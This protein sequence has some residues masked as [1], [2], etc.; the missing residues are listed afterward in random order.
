MLNVMKQ[1]ASIF[2]IIILSILGCSDCRNVDCPANQNFEFEVKNSSGNS[3]FKA[4]RFIQIIETD[5]ITVFGIDQSNNETE[6]PIY[7]DGIVLFFRPLKNINNYLVKYS[8]AKND[9]LAFDFTIYNDDCCN[10]VIT[11]YLVEVNS[12]GNMISSKTDSIFL[13]EK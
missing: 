2:I 11:E 10:S 12:N 13:F 3:L 1:T 5:S 4:T 6:L 7:Q 9:S 8:F